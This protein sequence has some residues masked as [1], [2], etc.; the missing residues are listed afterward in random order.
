MNERVLDHPAAKRALLYSDKASEEQLNAA[1]DRFIESERYSE[2][3]EFLELTRDAARLSRILDAALERGDTFLVLRVE[4][5]GGDEIPAD[6][7]R[8]IAAKA[9]TLG[10]FYDAYR[11]YGRAGDEE[12]AEAIRAE[13]MPDY[14]PFRPDGK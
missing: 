2:A 14:E 12:K 6:T 10:K 1:A 4:K 13:H 3:L 9:A 11:G 5:I 8:E 7:W